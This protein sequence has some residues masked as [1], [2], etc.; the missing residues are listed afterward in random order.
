MACLARASHA[1]DLNSNV[2]TQFLVVGVGVERDRLNV[3]LSSEV[4]DPPRNN[5]RISSSRTPA[6]TYRSLSQS[7]SSKSSSHQNRDHGHHVSEGP[8]RERFIANWMKKTVSSP[9]AGVLGPTSYSAVYDEGE[10][11]IK[12]PTVT[13][14]FRDFSKSLRRNQMLVDDTEIQ[15]G[16]ELLLFLYEDFTL[17]ERMSISK[18][19]HC[20]GYIFAPAVLRLL[21]ASV[22]QMLNNAIRDE[23]DPLSD[24]LELSKKIFENCSKTIRVDAHMTPQDYFI[25]MPDRWE[26]IGVIFSIIGSS[27]FLLPASD[28]MNLHPNS[29]NVDRQSLAL[30]SISAGEKCLKFCDNAGVMSEPLSW[31]LLAHA[32]LL[33]YVYG[34]HDYQPWKVLGNL[35]T[36]VY[37]LGFHQRENSEMLPFFHIEHRKRLLLGAYLVDKELATFLGR[38]PRISWRHIDVDLPLDIT[39]NELLAEP[40][41]RDAAIARLDQDGWNTQGI[42]SRITFARAMYKMGRVRE[43]VLELSLNSRHEDLDRKILETTNLAAEIRSKLPPRLNSSQF[44]DGV[45]IG[46]SESNLMARIFHLECL[47]NELIMQRILVKRTG[48]E[49]LGLRSIAH[50]M[51]NNL[52]VLNGNRAPD[53]RDNNTVAW[54]TSF[55]GLP[56]AGVLAIELLR[57]SQSPHPDPS[58]PRSEVIQNLSRFVGDLEFAIQREAGNYEI[59][60]HAR[61]LIRSIL[62]RVL[63]VPPASLNPASAEMSPMPIEWLGSDDIWLNQDPEFMRW[64]NNFDWN[65]EPSIGV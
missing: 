4:E 31:A 18:F 53:G 47:Y 44:L 40:E 1:G 11:V 8:L 12:S 21:F 15:V 9:G 28:M 29:A 65:Q 6:P 32:A 16:A 25:S 50:E 38:P 51:L 54:N 63:A 48:H 2:I 42:V 59:C 37:S 30:V 34:D 52:L 27:S 57:Q 14:S 35:S 60:Q 24:L 56:S 7:W 41:I 55:Y 61:K 33:T 49:S 22:R 3:I 64:I 13:T 20:E 23:S 58:F 43:L 39:Y 26:V 62:D 36:L 17:Y 19:N 46:E 10:E 45:T 5:T